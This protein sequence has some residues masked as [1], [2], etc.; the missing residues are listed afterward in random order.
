MRRQKLIYFFINCL[1]CVAGPL[2]AGTITYN[3]SSPEYWVTKSNGESQPK[4]GSENPIKS[5]YYKENNH[6]F[7]G[8]GNIYFSPEG[9]L[10][11]A[12]STIDSPVSLKLP[13]NADWEITKVILHSHKSGSEKTVVNIYDGHDGSS[14]SSEIKWIT[15]DADY[16]Y[17]ISS[18]SNLYIRAKDANARI[19]S[20]TI[21]YTSASGSTEDPSGSSSVSIPIFTPGT[22]SFSS[23]SL[24]VTIDAAERCDVFYT[25]DGT[26]PSTTNGTK[27]R[28]VTIYAAESKVKLQAMAVDSIT[29]E[30]SHVSSA[31]YTYV[32]MDND[33]TKSKPYTV[34]ELRTMGKDKNDK[35]VKGTICGAFDGNNNLVTSN[36]TI[37]TNIAIG[38]ESEHVA[39]QLPQ[40][41]MRNNVNLKDHPYMLGKEIL[42]KGNLESYIVSKGVG[43]KAPTDYEIFYSVPI[44]SY[45]WATLYLDIP[46]EFPA[47]STAFYCTTNGDQVRLL[48]VGNI[49]PDS[50]GV[51]I[52]STPNTICSLTYTTTTNPNEESVRTANQMIGFTKDSI[53]TMGDYDYYALNVK[54]NNLGFYIPNDTTVLDNGIITFNAKANK[55]YLEVPSEHS[56]TTYL[57]RHINDETSIVPMN[58]M[59]E[60]IIYDLQG[61][62][63]SSPVSGVYIKAGKKVVF[64]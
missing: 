15:K 36:I 53:A 63:V 30:C 54:D 10:L 6:C 47:G 60:D 13:T 56:V 21:E 22:S 25:K 20:V 26:T 44:N 38:D 32:K 4:T 12:K 61:R 14:V 23:E 41:S 52:Q 46:V 7:V 64:K 24:T 39:I 18:E 51:V 50:T 57:I 59:V 34:A 45:G 31:T 43:V 48:P 8:N 9:G 40:G 5:I 62:V 16:E 49:I 28:I 42:V 17:L 27:G 11:L 3:F 29:G 37:N 2:S 35:W 19:A 55:A 58:H 1:L 33:G